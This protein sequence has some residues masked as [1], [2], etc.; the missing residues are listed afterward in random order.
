M[1]PVG[2]IAFCDYIMPVARVQQIADM[3]PFQMTAFEAMFY[4]FALVYVPMGLRLIL[5]MG[6]GATANSTPRKTVEQFIATSK[7]GFR[8]H[9]AH[10][11]LVSWL[12]ICLVRACLLCYSTRIPSVGK[13]CFALFAGRHT[14]PPSRLFPPLL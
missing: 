2:I 14:P 10:N 9:S 8:L 1:I 5:Q 6:A 3:I 13:H 7:L 11:N 4:F 12:V